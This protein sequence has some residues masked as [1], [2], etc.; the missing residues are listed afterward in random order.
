MSFA[1][2]H[3]ETER[4][5]ALLACDILD[6]APEQA[7]D[8]VVSIAAHVAQ[9]PIALISLVDK[10]RQWFKARTGI[11]ATE[12]PREMA[13]CT[14]AILRPDQPLIVQDATTDRRFAQNPLVIEEPQI[15]FYCG[16]PLK[17]ANHEALGTLCVIDREPRALMIEQRNAL[18]ALARQVM[19]LLDLRRQMVDMKQAALDQLAYTD[20]LEE[21]KKALET[22]AIKLRSV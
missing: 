1:L 7:Y 15:R 2:P 5:R 13:F 20:Y 11:D 16:M 18:A 9:V 21:R 3:N 4:L 6:T 12:T 10:D 19:L 14:H 17:T 22:G 8:D